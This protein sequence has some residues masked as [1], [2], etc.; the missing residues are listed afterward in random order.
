M[1]Y[2]DSFQCYLQEEG[3]RHRTIQEYVAS[4]VALEKWVVEST[5]ENF[6][7]DFLTSRVLHEWLSFVQTVEKLA[8]ATINKRGVAIKVYWSYLV[9]TPRWL[10]HL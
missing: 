1:N 6:N 4:I 8:P 2:I 5:G 7:P 9:Q 10:I 3:K